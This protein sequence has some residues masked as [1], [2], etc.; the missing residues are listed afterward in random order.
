MN[1][2]GCET[3]IGMDWSATAIAREWWCVFVKL[4]SAGSSDAELQHYVVVFDI[5]LTRFIATLASNVSEL[6][7]IQSDVRVGNELVRRG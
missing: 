3:D 1:M 6:G 4:E 7:V 5:R 2:Q